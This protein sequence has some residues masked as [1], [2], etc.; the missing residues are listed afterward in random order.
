MNQLT[1]LGTKRSSSSLSALMI[2][3]T[4][5]SWSAVSRIWK[6][7]GSPASFQCAR[8]KRLHRPWKVPIHMPRTGSGSIAPSRVSISFAALLVKVTASTPPGDSW[9]VWISQAMRVVS[10]RVL[11]DPAPA[12]ISADR[13]GSVTAASCSG[14]R[15]RS[16]GIVD[17]RGGV[18]GE[19]AVGVGKSAVH[20]PLSGKAAN[21]WRRRGDR[22]AGAV[23]RFRPVR[24]QRA[25]AP[26]H[27]CRRRRRSGRSAA[28][29]S[30]GS[31]GSAGSS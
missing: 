25:A 15:P 1:C 31:A 30:A 17:R 4:A 16:S 3:L 24:R 9:P 19:L 14:L 21:R 5:D 23:R 22:S 7:C 28:A 12:R 11:P 26:P 13:G 27:R 20:A 2:R 8:R 6:P 18:G 10:T 29:R